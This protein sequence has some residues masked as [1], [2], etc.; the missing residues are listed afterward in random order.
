MS[1][2]AEINIDGTIGLTLTPAP[3]TTISNVKWNQDN[4]IGQIS[5]TSVPNKY[6]FTPSK[7]GVVKISATVDVKIN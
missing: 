5:P 7:A 3:G 2:E 4:P 1:T 6:L